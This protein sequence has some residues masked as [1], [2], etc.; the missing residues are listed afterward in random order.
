VISCD[1]LLPQFLDRIDGWV[2]LSSQLVLYRSEYGKKSGERQITDDHQIHI[3]LRPIP[4]GRGGTIDESRQDQPSLRKIGQ[5]ESYYFVRPYSLGDEAPDFLEDR[6]IG[7]CG[8]VDLPAVRLPKDESRTGQLFELALDGS[9]AAPNR[10]N[11]L[12][13]VERL[14][15]MPE[16]E[17]EHLPSSLSE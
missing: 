1:Q 14:L 13:K 4:S 11:D 3:A 16:Q 17:C 6:R 7:V 9:G 15:R 12:A 8:K 10:A 2:N 5:G